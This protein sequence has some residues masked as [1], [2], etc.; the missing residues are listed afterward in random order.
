MQKPL[1]TIDRTRAAASTSGC[2]TFT[3][4][5]ARC[6]RI[7]RAFWS[8]VLAARPF[9]NGI[10]FTA[11]VFSVGLAWSPRHP[12]AWLPLLGRSWL[13]FA[14]LFVIT[15]AARL[16]APEREA[17][18]APAA[19]ACR[20][21]AAVLLAGA[22]LVAI[23]LGRD[24]ALAAAGVGVLEAGGAYLVREAVL[25]DVLSVAVGVAVRAVAGALAIRV[26]VSPWLYLC[27]LLAA[28]FVAIN[29]KRSALLQGAASGTADLTKRNGYSPLLLNQ[30]STAVMAATLISYCLYTFSAPNL[31]R[32][33]GMMLT[34]PFVL[35][36]MFRYAYLAE[37]GGD[38]RELVL[39]DFPLL[40]CTA[41][42]ALAAGVIL[43]LFRM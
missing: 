6:V 38:T 30:M 41:L 19:L 29:E 17:T 21:A 32:N 3:K 24:F 5:A 39:R 7:G 22:A 33:H 1:H 42:W 26:P 10:A 2:V 31:P 35:Y 23:A 20:L 11:L 12:G 14:A 36:G 4:A 18:R 9:E 43:A 34:I 27:A 40:L 15:A 28:L 25:L 8:P 13:A 37:R 16:L